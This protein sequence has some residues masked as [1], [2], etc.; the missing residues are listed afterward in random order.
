MQAFTIDRIAE[1]A[2]EQGIELCPQ[3]V[4]RYTPMY[5]VAVSAGGHILPVVCYYRRRTL[6]SVV[7]TQSLCLKIILRYSFYLV[8]SDYM[9]D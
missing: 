8:S 1:L 9:R 2:E 5:R 7:A 3:C 4:G 6:F